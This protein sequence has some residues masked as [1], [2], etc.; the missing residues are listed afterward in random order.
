MNEVRR[1]D[2]KFNEAYKRLDEVYTKLSDEAGAENREL[3]E[4][5][6]AEIL[7]EEVENK[8]ER[9]LSYEEENNLRDKVLVSFS[10]HSIER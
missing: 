10:A 7:N 4:E 3:D 9:E 8:L 5:K 6:V 1:T 2:N